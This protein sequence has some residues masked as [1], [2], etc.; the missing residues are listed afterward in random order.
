M[1]D[2][3]GLSKGFIRT[4]RLI[5]AD[6]RACFDPAQDAII[7]WAERLGKP[8]T[9]EFTSRRT[10]KEPNPDVTGPDGLP[11]MREV[12]LPLCD[13]ES[14]TLKH[15]KKID[16]WKRFGSG[17]A[18]DD[19]LYEQEQDFREKR[20]LKFLQDRREY[21]KEHRREFADALENLKRG[22]IAPNQK[23]PLTRAQVRKILSPKETEAKRILIGV[24]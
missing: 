8:K 11:V 7:I 22:I 14:W 5:D 19:W 16:V 12:T 2:G 9:L 10:F 20:K 13:L 6:L 4:L 3:R 1:Y 18:F 21:L 24:K 17:K 23:R 15:L